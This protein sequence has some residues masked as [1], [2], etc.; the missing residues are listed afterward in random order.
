MSYIA[1][2]MSDPHQWANK[3]TALSG[4]FGVRA[5]FG[6]QDH[7]ITANN[8]NIATAITDQGSTTETETD[9]LILD[10][11]A[12]TL[13]QQIIQIIDGSAPGEAFEFIQNALQ[14]ES[15]D[16]I[17]DTLASLSYELELRGFDYLSALINE[18]LSLL[19]SEYGNITPLAE[20]HLQSILN[21]ITV[22]PNINLGDLGGM[23]QQELDNSQGGAM[24]C[25]VFSRISPLMT[26]IREQLEA[27]QT[28]AQQ[29]ILQP[30]AP[31]YPA[32][33]NNM[34]S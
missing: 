12:Q 1:A 32:F 3:P 17:Y 30:P 20:N 11:Y 19:V 31:S 2:E 8:T 23:V 28:P 18:E 10:P 4:Q 24:D 25:G 26:T 7:E 6:T 29:L 33:G 15:L 13:K 9:H 34:L 5:S 14:G 21:D 16:V 22:D 27:D